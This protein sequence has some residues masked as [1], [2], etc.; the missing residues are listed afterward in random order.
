MDIQKEKWIVRRYLAG[1]PATQ[2]AAHQQISIRTVRR[3]VQGYKKCGENFF[4]IQE[5]GRRKQ[6][7]SENFKMVVRD[8]WQ[9][10]QC[11][12]VKLHKI[13]SNKGF[14]VSQRKI[15][16]VLDEYNFTAPCPKRRGQR[17]YCSYRWP[18][19]TMVLH[20]DWTTCPVTKKQLI[21]FIDD[22][23]RFIVGH[24]LFDN[25]T[26]K[27]TLQCLYRILFE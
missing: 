15:Q 9:K 10:Y 21:A 27:N 11:G 8:C 17:K 25:A 23:S 20:T 24:G 14:G 2:I 5:I 22:H 26:T 19:C 4:E 18:S 7:I 16:H 3:K 13:L 12:S 6:P 1:M